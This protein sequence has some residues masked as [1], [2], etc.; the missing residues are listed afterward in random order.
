[1]TD[2]FFNSR[3]IFSDFIRPQGLSR[4]GSEIYVSDDFG[5]SIWKF[6]PSCNPSDLE[7]VIADAVTPRQTAIRN[8]FI[9]T[10]TVSSKNIVRIPYY[11]NNTCSIDRQVICESDS[12]EWIDGNIY[13]SANNTASMTFQNSDGCDS[14]VILNLTVNETNT[15]I[16]VFDGTLTSNEQDAEYQWLNCR[17]GHGSI[18]GETDITFIPSNL[19]SY[20]LE[21]T[22][23]GCVDTTECRRVSISTSVKDINLDAPF[24]IYPT[25]TSNM[26]TID[27]DQISSGKIEVFTLVGQM[28]SEYSISNSTS[29]DFSLEG[30]T[31]IHIIR[32]Q[33][34]NRS[35]SMRVLK[36]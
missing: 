11:E 10:M 30:Q 8:N 26:L 9:F 17:D 29:F 15:E 33:L 28:V 22:K 13:T 25:P 7:L 36:N 31:G 34:G 3:V 6:N 5:R 18:F 4:C 1:M 19:G 35:W 12:L 2:A 27:F 24:E 14:L 20:A 32:V 23:N 16:S 21:I